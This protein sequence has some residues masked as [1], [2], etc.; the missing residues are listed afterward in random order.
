MR[1]SRVSIHRRD[2]KRAISFNCA[3]NLVFFHQCDIFAN[4]RVVSR[5]AENRAQMRVAMDVFPTNFIEVITR[6]LRNHK[7]ADEARANAP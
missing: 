3:T 1:V 4:P 5:D 7:L 6:D 2:H